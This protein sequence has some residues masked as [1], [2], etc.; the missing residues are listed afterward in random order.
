MM[1]K[2][3]MLIWYD[4]GGDY[5]EITFKRC[6]DTYFNEIEKNIE[7]IR[8]KKNNAL[9]GFAIFNFTKRKEKS[10]DMALQIPA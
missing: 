2:Q 6:K 1:K 9:V 4:K 10:I 5:L 7:E 8:D 3:K